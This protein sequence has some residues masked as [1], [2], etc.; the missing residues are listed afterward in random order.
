[1]KLPASM[2]WSATKRQVFGV[3]AQKCAPEVWQRLGRTAA[4]RDLTAYGYVWFEP[5]KA[6]K[7]A[8]ARWL[9]CSIILSG[10]TTLMDLPTNRT[11]LVPRRRGDDIAR[12]LTK[13]IVNT[14]CERRHA[15]RATGTFTLN[16]ATRP[17][18]KSLNKTATRRCLP[19]VDRHKYYRF[20]YKDPAT[21]AAG[22]HTVVCYTKTST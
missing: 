15:W 6:D 20:T 2:D 22:D 14:V 8:G 7:S 3:V 21:W 12:C 4:A 9:S 11:P 13:S 5:T 18:A 10:G 19:V 16:V 1:V 17:S